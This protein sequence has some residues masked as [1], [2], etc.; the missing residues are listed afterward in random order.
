MPDWVILST[1]DVSSAKNFALDA[2]SLDELFM[3]IRKGNGPS[4]EPCGTPASIVVHEDYYSFRITLCFCCY[5]AS[6]TIFSKLPD[7]LVSLSLWRRSL[8]QT[9]SKAFNIL[10]DTSLVS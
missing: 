7:I 6:V 2:K 10:R 4:I 9:L 3:Y 5:K 8:C 1:T